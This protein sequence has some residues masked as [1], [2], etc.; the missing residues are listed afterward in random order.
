MLTDREKFNGTSVELFLVNGAYSPLPARGCARIRIVRDLTAPASPDLTV[1]GQHVKRLTESS[2]GCS[3]T[4]LGFLS[5]L[6]T[7]TNIG[8][9]VVSACVKFVGAMRWFAH[10]GGCSLKRG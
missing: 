1:Q 9:Q 3:E 2:K 10:E 4:K 5:G 6:S 7:R 8:L